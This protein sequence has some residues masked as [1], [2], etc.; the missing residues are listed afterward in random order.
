MGNTD[1]DKCS[2]VI[3]DAFKNPDTVQDCKAEDIMVS[4][5][6]RLC[7]NKPVIIKENAS[8]EEVEQTDELND[9]YHPAFYEAMTYMFSKDSTRYDYKKEL[10]LNP[11]AN[12]IDFII[13]K[14]DD[15]I[16][17]VYTIGKIFRKYNI[18]EY[19][20]PNTSLGVNEYFLA[21]GYA[22]LYS[23]YYKD[24]DINDITIS[25]VREGK[26]RKL[27]KYLRENGFE[28]SMYDTGIYHV[29]KS[30]HVDMQIIVTRRLSDEY[31]W[32]KTL[33]PNLAMEHDP[34]MI[35][36][37]KAIYELISSLIKER[38]WVKELSGMSSMEIFFKDEWKE[39]IKHLNEQLESKNK[40]LESKDK[41]LH[42]KDKELQ[43]EKK[44]NNKLLKENE[45]LKKKIAML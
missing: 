21:M 10:T 11:M 42:D 16:Q 14:P 43:K 39:E 7:Q 37:I 45:R 33:T 27:M 32:I 8:K 25:F 6:E 29:R 36:H 22:Y 18:F 40:Q 28:I 35:V 44:E 19:K 13:I 1:H 24:V 17:S 23:S 31:I 4:S 20:S 38:E 2:C 9:Q 12:K 15:D 30:G 5:S 34:D 26:P 41:Q 3:N